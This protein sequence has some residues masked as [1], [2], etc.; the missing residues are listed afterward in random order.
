[1]KTKKI[2]LHHSC[3]CGPIKSDLKLFQITYRSQIC[4]KVIDRC[5]QD[6]LN[7]YNEGKRLFLE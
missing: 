1:M 6:A 3:K 2:K 4:S 7:L 5:Y